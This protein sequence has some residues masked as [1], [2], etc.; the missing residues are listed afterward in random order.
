MARKFK[1]K[2]SS[3]GV[4]PSHLNL[5]KHLTTERNLPRH[6]L[7]YAAK[8]MYYDEKWTEKQER[9]KEVGT[10]MKVQTPQ[11]LSKHQSTSIPTVLLR[12]LY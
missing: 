5:T 3:K 11:R 2:V 9:G 7:P 6:P 12:T 4:A 1:A 8:N 10:Y